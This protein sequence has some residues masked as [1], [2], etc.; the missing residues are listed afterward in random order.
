LIPTTENTGSTPITI[1]DSTPP[2]IMIPPDVVSNSPVSPTPAQSI[3]VSTLLKP[4]YKEKTLPKNKLPKP[5]TV[6][7]VF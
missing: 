1:V 6:P 3:T 7:W 5:F 2:P 4:A